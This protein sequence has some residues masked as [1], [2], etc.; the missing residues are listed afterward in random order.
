MVASAL[1]FTITPT[2]FEMSAAPG[3]S[4]NSSVKVVND[5]DF[6]I[7]VYAKTQN[8]VPQGERGQ[9]VFIPDTAAEGSE[10]T[11]AA[12]ME[13]PSEAITIPSGETVSVPVTISVP[14]DAPPGG[15]YAAVLIGT[16]PP[17]QRG[18]TAVRTAQVISSL[19]LVRIA[20]DIEEAGTIRS[21]AGTTNIT[22]TP[23]MDFSLRFENQGNVHLRPQG[24]IQITNMWGKERGVIPINHKTHFGNVL[25]ESIREFTFSWEGESVWLDFGRY[26]AQ[27]TLGYGVN[28]R[29]FVTRT[30]HFWFIPL[31]PILITLVGIVLFGFLLSR[32]VRFYIKRTLVRAGINPDQARS[33]YA[34]TRPARPKRQQPGDVHITSQSAAPPESPDGWM[35]RVATQIREILTSERVQHFVAAYRRQLVWGTSVVFGLIVLAWF[36]S[37]VLTPQRNYEVT[38]GEEEQA[39][40]LSSEEVIADQR[41]QAAGVP[42]ETTASSSYELRLINAGSEPGVTY[43]AS[44]RLKTAGFSVTERD[45]LLDEDRERTVVVYTTALAD[46]AVAIS[47]LLQNALVSAAPETATSG[48]TVYLGSDYTSE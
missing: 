32:L 39:T 48:I 17:E 27:A 25:P 38:V 26:T 1:S 6:P 19:F 8:F 30:D 40:R 35:L 43:E 14:D 20:G 11:L 24:E 44:E 41:R 47:K 9:G 46:E 18:D 33:M 22:Q 7:T 37:V 3:Q 10:A 28:S 13:V 29:Q 15:H 21:F 16:Q 5:N 4:W 45:V 31:R 36:L 12:W 2:L 23:S 42:E 34:H